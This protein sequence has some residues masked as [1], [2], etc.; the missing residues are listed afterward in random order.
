LMVQLNKLVEQGNT[1][2]AVEHDMRVIAGS[3]WVVDIGPGA[4]EEGGKVVVTGTPEK[5]AGDK[6]SKTE[7]YLRRYLERN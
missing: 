6:K 3:D 4:G 7:V 1:V 5:V 2:I